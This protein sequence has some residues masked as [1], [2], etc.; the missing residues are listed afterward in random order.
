MS[1]A[2]CERIDCFANK[3]GAFCTILNGPLKEGYDCPF[4]KTEAEYIKGRNDA[5]DRLVRERL[6]ELINKYEV[7]EKDVRDCRRKNSKEK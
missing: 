2:C 6:D 4:Y 7:Q 3:C 5:H 1:K